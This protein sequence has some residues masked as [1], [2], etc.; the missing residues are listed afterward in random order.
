MKNNAMAQGQSA[1]HRAWAKQLI[2]SAFSEAGKQ[3]DF[4]MDRQD[5][6]PT[7]IP[8]GFDNT[9]MHRYKPTPLTLAISYEKWRQ[10]SYPD[11]LHGGDKTFR[12][13]RGSAASR[14]LNR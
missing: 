6:D 2:I 8:L 10:S 3:K 14:D 13:L 4:D 5:L 7:K 12:K 1:T 9:M 11:L